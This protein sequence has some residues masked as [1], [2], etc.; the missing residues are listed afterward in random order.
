MENP[1]TKGSRASCNLFAD[2]MQIPVS[3]IA[4]QAQFLAARYGFTPDLAALVAALAF[5][6]ANHG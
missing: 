4:M 2:K 5:G 3:T 1:T 6:G